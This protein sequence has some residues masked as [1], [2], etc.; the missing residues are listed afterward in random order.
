[1]TPIEMAECERRVRKWLPSAFLSYNQAQQTYKVYHRIDDCQ[2]ALSYSFTTAQEAWYTAV[3]H[4]ERKF[5]LPEGATD[6]DLYEVPEG[7]SP[8]VPRGEDMS[9]LQER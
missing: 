2:V 7:V 8:S 4:V 9:D 1:M 5:I 3:L 6:A